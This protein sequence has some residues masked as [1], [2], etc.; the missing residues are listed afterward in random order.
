MEFKAF[1]VDMVRSELEDA[2]GL[3]VKRSDGLGRL[4]LTAAIIS[5][6]LNLR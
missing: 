3:V 2:V 4:I 6:K 5:M 1:M